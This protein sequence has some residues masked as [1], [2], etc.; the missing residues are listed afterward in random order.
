MGDS[1]EPRKD[2]LAY[3]WQEAP[4]QIRGYLRGLRKGSKR[5]SEY[6]INASARPHISVRPVAIGV[7]CDV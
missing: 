7:G 4:A 1:L 3:Y 2:R 5:L 6:R